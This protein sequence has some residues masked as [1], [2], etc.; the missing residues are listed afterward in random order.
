M[1]DRTFDGQVAC[2]A[3][4]RPIVD[5]TEIGKGHL[6]HTITNLRIDVWLKLL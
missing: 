3:K 2:R 4:L 1:T 6:N 5:P